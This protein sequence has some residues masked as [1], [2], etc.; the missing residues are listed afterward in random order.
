MNTISAE[1][2]YAAMKTGLQ[3]WHIVAAI[4]RE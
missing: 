3:R 1:V 2:D 4:I